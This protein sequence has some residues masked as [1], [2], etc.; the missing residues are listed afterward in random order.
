MTSFPAFA[1]LFVQKYS[2]QLIKRKL[3]AGLEMRSFVKYCFYHSKIKFI[4]SCRRVI[5]SI[6]LVFSELKVLG[7]WL[8]NGVDED[9]RYKV[10]CFTESCQRVSRWEN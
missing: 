2:C 8:L 4:S 6:F 1:L 9:I 7:H 5:S 10:L 3:H